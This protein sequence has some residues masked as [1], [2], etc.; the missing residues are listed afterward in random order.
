ML[1]GQGLLPLEPCFQTQILNTAILHRINQYYHILL[2]TFCRFIL[3][4][5]GGTFCSF[6][7]FL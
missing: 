4:A 2:K 1:A 6:S 3:G 7:K 5:F